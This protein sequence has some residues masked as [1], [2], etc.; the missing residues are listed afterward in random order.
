MTEHPGND[1]PLTRRELRELE[2]RRVLEASAAL[3]E[4][5]ASPLTPGSDGPARPADRSAWQPPAAPTSAGPAL[6]RRELR[7]RNVEVEPLRLSVP[8]QS[9]APAIEAP[10]AAG[11]P[12][13][14][15]TPTAAA[16]PSAEGMPTGAGMPTG[17][18]GSVAASASGV[19]SIPVSMIREHANDQ[20][21]L[22]ASALAAAVQGRRAGMRDAAAVRPRPVEGVAAGAAAAE[23]GGSVALAARTGPTAAQDVE[24]AVVTD[25]FGMPAV[26]MDAPVLPALRPIEEIEAEL[27]RTALGGSRAGDGPAPAEPDEP[28]GFEPAAGAG[29]AAGPGGTIEPGTGP[30][31]YGT[32]RVEPGAG[33]VSPGG[34]V[35][36]AGAPDA[37]PQ[38][39][40]DAWAF[41]ADVKPIQ[42]APDEP[43]DLDLPELA[44]AVGPDHADPHLPDSE[45]SGSELSGS[46]L[47]DSE[48]P[49][50]GLPNPGLPDR[51]LPDPEPFTLD[52]D[53]PVAAG[54]ETLA[55]A[56]VARRFEPVRT[57]TVPNPRT[58]TSQR[59]GLEPGGTQAAPPAPRRPRAQATAPRSTPGDVLT[60]PPGRWQAVYGAWIGVAAIAVWALGPVALVLGI[61]ALVQAEAEGFGRGRPFTAIVGGALGTI[62]GVLFLAFGPG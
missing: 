1:A 52:D 32:G 51:E 61:W 31:A 58:V 27:S 24:P 45:L 48:L 56:S 33:P 25:G 36:P 17:V 10:S 57:S 19:A 44:D 11:M 46:H 47:P 3:A 54:H 38:G 55:E 12:T 53:A 35:A 20:D 9:P 43:A 14:A 42:L 18:E 13:G 50:P 60:L 8:S 62:L 30:A 41:A 37:W 40:P 2:R 28:S 7:R 6:T 29:P 59:V 39:D 5:A 22:P 23:L 26:F 49:D 16:M 34:P 15:G 21:H 4:L